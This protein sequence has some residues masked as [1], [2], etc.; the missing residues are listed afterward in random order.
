MALD[1]GKVR[2][3]VEKTWDESIVPT[4]TDYITIPAKSPMFDAQWREHGHIDRAV[5]LLRGW[6]GSR[7][8]EGLRIE[9]V[10]LE[11]RTPLLFM[12]APGTRVDTVLLYCHLE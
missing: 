4:L 2:E 6:A 3:F 7:P 12:E 9:V 10:R 11:G 1:S 5:E 8:I